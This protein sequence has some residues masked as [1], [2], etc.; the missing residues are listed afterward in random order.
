MQGLSESDFNNY[1]KVKKLFEQGEK[2]MEKAN[3]NELL[4]ICKEIWGEM[5]DQNTEIEKIKGTGL[6]S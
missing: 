4:A 3:H 6:G 2:A 1:K 5:K